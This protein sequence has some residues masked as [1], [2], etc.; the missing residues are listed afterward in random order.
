MGEA[1]AGKLMIA[2]GDEVDWE[3]SRAISLWFLGASSKAGVLAAALRAPACMAA[4]RAELLVEGE[5][6][7]RPEK[8]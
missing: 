8:R 6:L 1:D 4:A 7:L 2:D 3:S 5:R